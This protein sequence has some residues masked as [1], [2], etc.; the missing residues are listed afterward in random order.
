VDLYRTVADLQRRLHLERSRGKRIGMVGTSGA[1]HD[2]HLSLVR[3]AAVANDLT[4]I[5]WGGSSQ[6]DWMDSEL[7]YERDFDRD[8]RLVESAGAEA[9][10][11]PYDEELF[12][13][14][15]FTCVSLPEV[16][17]GTEGLEDP[18]H[19][20]LIATVMCKLWNIFG[21]CQSYFGE[22]DWQQLA[23]FTRLADDLSWPVQVVGCP[24]VREADGLALSSRNAKLTPA[25]RSAAPILYR[26]LVEC[27]ESARNGERS[28]YGLRRLFVDTIGDA[29][30]LEY[31]ITVDA[32]T[33]ARK[34]S[35][36]GDVR[37]LGSVRF[38]SVR[39]VDNI[40]LRLD[41]VEP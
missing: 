4:V 20:D 27:A 29:A 41:R 13:R 12:A 36:R 7:T 1:V 10:F 39:L 35:L 16:S 26:A 15:P 8:Q 2:G 23:M 31:F 22:K 6:F 3:A 30:S 38:D 5:F 25:Q 11:M 32:D 40:G 21:P 37:L 24:T 19:L 17:S 18:A 34:D 28:L 33:M 14:R 9:I